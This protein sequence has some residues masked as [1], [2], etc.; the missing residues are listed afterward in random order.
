MTIRPYK[1]PN[2]VSPSTELNTLPRK[3]MSVFQ[4]FM[5]VYTATSVNVTADVALDVPF[6][7]AMASDSP[8]KAAGYECWQHLSFSKINYA[9]VD[10]LSFIS[11]L[12]K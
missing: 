12:S 10:L 4:D 5:S 6:I 2:D 9:T 8:E 1:I 3:L 11:T 7:Q